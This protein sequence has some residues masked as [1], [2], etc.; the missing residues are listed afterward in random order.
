MLR[1]YF[2]IAL[3]H[4][5]KNKLY[6]FVNIVGLAIGIASCLFIG[7]YIWHEL[8]YDRFHTNGDRITRVTWE[9]QF[10]DA[11]TKTATT[12]TKVGPQFQRTF[13]EVESYAR[14]MKYPRVISYGDKMFEE[15]SFL[16]ADSAFFSIFSFQL[17]KGNAITVLDA[18]GKLVVSESMGKKYF[19]EED[20]VGKMVKV[21]IKDFMVTGVVADAPGNSQIQ[22]DFI[23]SFCSLNASR[24]EK[25]SEANY[26]TYL[27]L[28]NAEAIAPLQNKI[29]A[30]ID[31]VSKEEMNTTGDQYMKYHLEPISR[32]RL[33]SKLDGLEPNNNIVYIYILGAVA[34]LI[35]LIAG[36]NYTNLSTAQ[37]ASRTSEIG[38][39]KVMGAKRVQV[40]NQ[41]ICETFLITLLAVVLALVMCTG[42]VPYFNTLSGKEFDS[43]IFFKPFTLLSLLILASVVSFTAG[44]YPA[45]ILSAGKVIHILKSGFHFT[46][47]GALR[48][49]LIVFQF[50][51][52]VFL[53]IATIVILQQLSFIQN[54][55]LGYD[56]EQVIILP[57]DSKISEQYDDLKRTLSSTPN[58]I[59]IGGAYESPAHIGWSDGLNRPADDKNISINALPVDEDFVKTIGLKII[60]GSDYTWADVQAFDTTDQGNN[61]RYSFMLNE[62]AVKAL[63]WT[64]EE[65]I[66]QTV[67]KGREGTIK[68]VVQDFHFRSFHE[69][70]SPMVLFL[71]KRM[72]GSI[73]IKISGSNTQN[74]IAGLE[75][76]WRS[77]VPH[78]PFEYTFLD[79]EFNDLYKT[80][81]RTAG[82]FST[83][84]FIAVLLACL[85]LFALTAYSMVQRTKEIGIRKILGASVLDILSL[86]SKDFIRLVLL[87]MIIAIPIAFFATNKWL[88]GFVYKTSLHWWVFV[89]AGLG[90]LLISFIA[91]SLQAI[92]TSVANPVKNLRTE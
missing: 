15:K 68:A 61:I 58:V 65:A 8:S 67:L 69:A 24:E 1:N 60:A 39:R 92:K 78:R 17:L 89:I 74:T 13:P 77:R 5:Q 41:F 37:S 27:L 79:D 50:V 75:K 2:K 63:G 30:Y 71:D 53:I 47:S 31:K 72:L 22:F 26:V 52:S 70:I 86:V 90:T 14:L 84:A 55:D 10:G 38:M 51:I 83:F 36:V 81:Q 73:F 35:L 23:G 44:A 32:V 18:P 42:L 91:I 57:V 49:S 21:G 20:P 64:P 6:A 46:G 80:E 54:K 12:G 11:T 56:K 40:F 25:W 29:Y 87:A 76:I 3:R 16:Y 82:V 19:G 62:A 33:H 66:G 85:G 4:L 28:N 9:Y 43:E 7:V 45:I 59:S 34:I 48:K 88:E